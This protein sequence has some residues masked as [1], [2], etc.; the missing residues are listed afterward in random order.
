VEGKGLWSNQEDT[1]PDLGL[2]RGGG[3]M[4]PGQIRRKLTG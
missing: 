1:A 3:K 2:L 4:R